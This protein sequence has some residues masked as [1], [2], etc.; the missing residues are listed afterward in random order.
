M[1]ANSLPCPTCGEP[2]VPLRPLLGGYWTI[3]CLRHGTANVFAR[4]MLEES[5]TAQELRDEALE[6]VDNNPAWKSFAVPA[7]EAVARRQTE[8][9]SEDVWDELDSMG[10][11]RPTEGRV[12]GPVFMAAVK[13]GTIVPLGYTLAT[14]PKHHAMPKHTYRSAIFEG[15]R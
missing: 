9:T 3:R 15:D 5:P 6:R 8:L 14:N 13:A 1:T 11:P 4:K 2:S 7:L 10:I 12:M